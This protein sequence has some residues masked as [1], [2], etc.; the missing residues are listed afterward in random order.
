M[1]PLARYR[2]LQFSSSY[3]GQGENPPR[4]C[5]HETERLSSALWGARFITPSFP[6]SREDPQIGQHLENDTSSTECDVSSGAG[7]CAKTILFTFHEKKCS[8]ICSASLYRVARGIF[9]SSQSVVRKIVVQ[10]LTLFYCVGL[11][12]YCEGVIL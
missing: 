12:Q 5:R 2:G 7:T 1:V 8:V 11:I 10:E 6:L 9:A 3:L 4:E